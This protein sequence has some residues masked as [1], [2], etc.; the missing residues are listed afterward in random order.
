[1]NYR[2]VSKLAQFSC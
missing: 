1:M 2:N